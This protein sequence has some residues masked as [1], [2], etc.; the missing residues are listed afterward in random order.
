LPVKFNPLV[1]KQKAIQVAAEPNE[2][3]SLAPHL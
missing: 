2:F 1:A 3:A